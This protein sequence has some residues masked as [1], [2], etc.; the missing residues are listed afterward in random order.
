MTF[1]PFESACVA[2]G[3]FNIYILKP[4]FIADLM[5]CSVPKPLKYQ[6]DFD[7]PGFQIQ[8]EDPSLTWTIRPDGIVASSRDPDASCGEYV[9]KVLKALPV[10]PMQAIGNN[11]H[12][13]ASSDEKSQD[14]PGSI[15]QWVKDTSAIEGA[16][17]R[18]VAISI[19]R[20]CTI[21]NLSLSSEGECFSV[22]VNVHRGSDFPD[23][24]PKAAE[25]FADDRRQAADL[26]QEVFKVEL[27]EC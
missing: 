22:G 18:A 3:T 21:F 26:V 9:A 17:H 13:R 5:G 4:D 19:T 1:E 20:N 14:F 8:F 2:K 16:T 25:M 6:A 12:F 15:R 10:T 23:G 11:F 27:A 7:R 24:I